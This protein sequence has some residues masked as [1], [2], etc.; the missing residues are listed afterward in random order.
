MRRVVPRSR[1]ERS[2]HEPRTLS[3]SLGPEVESAHEE[4]SDAA[5]TR[6]S[7][8][9]GSDCSALTVSVR[10]PTESRAEHREQSRGPPRPRALPRFLPSPEI[11]F[12]AGPERERLPPSREE[13]GT[14]GG[15]GSPR[16]E[17]VALPRGG[18]KRAAR[19]GGPFP[20]GGRFAERCAPARLPLEPPSVPGTASP[21]ERPCRAASRRT[22]PRAIA[23]CSTRWRRLS[24][25]Y[26]SI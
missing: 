4:A 7:V 18:R 19:F 22:G 9:H 12:P 13:W 26:D 1:I 23:S 25:I 16:S 11:A 2:S 20:F 10:A 17:R 5:M 24:G 6:V 14:C 3:G 21:G 8:S 15:Q